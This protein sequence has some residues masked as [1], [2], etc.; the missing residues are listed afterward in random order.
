MS[1][2]GPKNIV[3]VGGGIA[4]LAAADAITAA[5]EPLALAGTLPA[6]IEVLLV[7]GEQQVGGRAMTWNV[8]AIDAAE[9]PHRHA[10]GFT[11]HGIHFLWGSY[12]HFLEWTADAQHV[13]SPERPITTYCAWLT[14]PDLVGPQHG[15]GKVVAL[16][17][18]DPQEPAT[19]WDPR[20]RAI[21]EAFQRG[22]AWVSFL[23][24]FVRKY[25][26][27]EIEVDDWLASIDVLFDEKNLAP[28]LRWGMLLLPAFV[29]QIGRVEKSPE[30]AALLGGRHPQ[31]VEVS[32]LVAPFFQSILVERMRDASAALAP[33][34]A[35]EPGPTSFAPL[36]SAIAAARGG[37]LRLG[38]KLVMG[39]QSVLDGIGLLPEAGRAGFEL[40]RLMLRDARVILDG[41]ARFDPRQSGYMKNLYKAAFSSPYQFDLATALR[42]VQ[43]GF[44][45]HQTAKLQVFDGDDAQAL[46]NHIRQRIEARTLKGVDVSIRTGTWVKKIE[47]TAGKVSGVELTDSVVRAPRPI[48]TIEPMG[49]GAVTETRAVD[50]LVSTLLPACLKP[51][52]T[53]G[54]PS[55][56]ELRRRVGALARYANETVNLQIL[57][58][59][60]IELPFVDPPNALESKPFSISNL[61]GPFTIL[62]DLSRAWR[63]ATFRALR[64][65]AS[66]VDFTGSA[67]EL[68]GS[69]G[70]AFTHDAHAA[71]SRHQWPLGTQ[72]LLARLAHD[73]D[74]L[75]SWSVDDRQW[76]LD[77][78]APGALPAPLFGE[79]KRDASVRA[80][81]FARW[82]DK[83]GPL[84][85]EQTLRQIAALPGLDVRD[86]QYLKDLAGDVARGLPA[87]IKFI[88][89]TSRQA[90]TKFFS[91]EPHTHE[92]RPHARFE[93]PVQGL[94]C[95]G[96]WTRGGLNVQAMEGALLS[97]LHAAAGVLESMKDHGLDVRG[98]HIIPDMVP[99]GAWDPGP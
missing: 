86:R 14:P 90:E 56:D 18:C 57:L 4:G 88:F 29:A 45:N 77:A 72:H 26:V 42:D 85:V 62:V 61:E 64:F 12:T 38:E 84:V 20:A 22:D 74:D 19:A 6:G 54:Q 28:E 66:N 24:K 55:T 32:E 31:D 8:D 91:A 63:P 9:H 99:N 75:E 89:S 23:E 15:P 96:D 82:V 34:L 1:Y 35:G 47:V 50:A 36:D 51:L 43:M 46:W 53:P 21:L 40:M 44:R 93:T 68:V 5:L 27:R 52:L 87:P 13:F 30:L 2:T 49:K 67:W 94:W 60:R 71:P 59:R 25:L 11:P 81:Y 17:V 69:W 98:P 16:H 70:D 79:V 97:G 10:R 65:D 37:T 58:A 78:G 41:A 73:P 48:S 39:A 76:T 92:L 95:A 80:A 3:I 33:F 7:E 83:I